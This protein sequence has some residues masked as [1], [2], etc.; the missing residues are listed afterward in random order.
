MW[1]DKFDPRWVDLRN[2]PAQPP[3][4]YAEQP[5]GPPPWLIGPPRMH[6]AARVFVAAVGLACAGLVV[7]AAVW[8]WRLLDRITDLR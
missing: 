1:S 2:D 4:P 6:P 8:A 5:P 7:S 3:D